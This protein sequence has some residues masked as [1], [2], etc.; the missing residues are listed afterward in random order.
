MKKPVIY[1]AGPYRP[2][3][4]G[5]CWAMEQNIRRAEALALEVWACGAVALCPH[6]MTRHYQG[7][8]PDAVWLD[9][10]LEIL[11]RCDAVVLVEGWES[12]EGTKREIEEAAIIDMPVLESHDLAEWIRIRRLTDEP[13]G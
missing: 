8:L 12:S 4:Q 3:I 5:D 9:G 13:E 1:V 10:D 7:A 11:R 6:T 2:R